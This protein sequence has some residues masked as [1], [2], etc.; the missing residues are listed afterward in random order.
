MRPYNLKGLTVLPRFHCLTC[1]NDSCM[2]FKLIPVRKVFPARGYMERP[3]GKESVMHSRNG[4]FSS[5]PVRLNHGVRAETRTKYRVKTNEKKQMLE[6]E[7]EKTP[8]SS[9][10][11]ISYDGCTQSFIWPSHVSSLVF[12]RCHYTRLGRIP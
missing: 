7:R 9:G 4:K 8:E 11:S 2:W 10:P 5:V 6:K 3:Q 1:R 12:W